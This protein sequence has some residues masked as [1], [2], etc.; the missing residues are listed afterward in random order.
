MYC[1]QHYAEVTDLGDLILY[2]DDDPY[3]T[4][5]FSSRKELTLFVNYLW[6]V[7]DEAWPAS[8]SD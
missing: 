5:H 6:A 3:Y 2:N 1:A 8:E 4:Q 7:A